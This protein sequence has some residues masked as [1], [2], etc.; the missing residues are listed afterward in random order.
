MRGGVK[1]A[2]PQDSPGG[3]GEQGLASAYEALHVHQWS[4][5]VVDQ[6]CSV[7][8]PP[9][10]FPAALARAQLRKLKR[11]QAPCSAEQAKNKNRKNLE[12][13]SRFRVAEGQGKATRHIP[14]NVVGRGC[15]V[16]RA[17]VEGGWTPGPPFATHG[18]IGAN[19]LCTPTAMREWLAAVPGAW[20]DSPPARRAW[21]GGS[22]S[23]NRAAAVKAFAGRTTGSS[24]EGIALAPITEAKRIAALTPAASDGLDAPAWLSVFAGAASAGED[25]WA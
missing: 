4:P 12:R 20:L 2:A 6:A 14:L 25:F 8:P 3:L 13:A 16:T 15:A 17:K 1:L 9:S 21:E 11:G 18:D 23:S 22:L 7:G 5:S 24:P 10:P 19:A